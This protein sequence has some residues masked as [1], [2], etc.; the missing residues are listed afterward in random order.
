MPVSYAGLQVPQR[1]AMATQT[2]HIPTAVHAA[3]QRGEVIEAIR[4]LR[5]GTGLGLREAR[6]AVEALQRIGGGITSMEVESGAHGAD[7]TGDRH[8]HEL[9]LPPEVVTALSQGN[10]IEAIKRLRALQPMALR[11]AKALVERHR[12]AAK[13][14]HTPTVAPG[15]SGGGLWLWIVLALIAIAGWAWWSGSS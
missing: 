2:I 4:L 9:R 6:D 3:L 5:E 1:T 13:P 12:Q 15:D 8:A 10:V 7:R 11:D 14:R